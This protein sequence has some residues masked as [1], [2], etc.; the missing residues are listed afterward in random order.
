MVKE[1]I[2]AI[3][4]GLKNAIERGESIEKA[5]STFLNAGYKSEDIE[6]AAGLLSIKEINKEEKTA[7]VKENKKEIKTLTKEKPLPEI[8]AGPK[9]KFNIIRAV[10]VAAAIVIVLL[11]A[12]L[13]VQILAAK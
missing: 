2:A 5:K 1:E 10:L 11:I 4:G 3:L 6:E 7:K 9:K 12:Y 13:T 8:N